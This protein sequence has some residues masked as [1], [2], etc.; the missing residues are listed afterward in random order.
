MTLFVRKSATKLEQRHE[1]HIAKIENTVPD[2]ISAAILFRSD[3]GTSAIRALIIV[4]FYRSISRSFSK[5]Q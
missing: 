2:V 1:I 5:E 4:R 3:E